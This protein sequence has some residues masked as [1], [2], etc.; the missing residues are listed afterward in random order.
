[1]HFISNNP[2][3][4]NTI[5]GNYKYQI[6]KIVTAAA[7]VAAAAAAATVAVHVPIR[8]CVRGNGLLL[9]GADVEFSTMKYVHVI[10]YENVHLDCLHPD[11]DTI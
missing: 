2:L 10:L 8:S 4:N 11:F 5:G 1:M 6:F 3:G 7:A 9:I